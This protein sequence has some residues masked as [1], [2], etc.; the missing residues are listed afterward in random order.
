M[1]IIY[2]SSRL[3]SAKNKTAGEI[4]GWRETRGTRARRGEHRTL[5]QAPPASCLPSLAC[6][7]SLARERVSCS[8]VCLSPKFGIALS[9]SKKCQVGNITGNLPRRTTNSK[10]ITS[11]TDG[12]RTKTTLVDSKCSYPCE[13]RLQVVSFFWI[14]TKEQA[15]CT[16]AK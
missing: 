12:N 1:I 15:K 7:P 6:P 13:N 2:A 11:S 10:Y 8:L 9:R 3:I 16:R 4:H 14:E 5:Q